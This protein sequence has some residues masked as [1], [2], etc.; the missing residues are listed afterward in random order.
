[1]RGHT[2]DVTTLAFSPDGQFIVSGS[3]DRTL[4]LWRV[5]GT[6]VGN[7]FRGHTS[8]VAAVAFGPDGRTIVS[9]SRDQTLRLWTLSG[10]PIGNPLVGHK[11]TVHGVAFSP[12]GLWIVS[13]GEDGTLRRW[14]GG[15]DPDWIQWGCDRLNSHTLF[16]SQTVRAMRK[17]CPL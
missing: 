4:R 5:D 8:K 3:R 17:I 14:E 1:M 11:G 2:D 7:P 12:D 6:P 15:Y 13:G 16:K 10:E 9:A